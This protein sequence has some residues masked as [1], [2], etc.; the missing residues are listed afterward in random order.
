MRIVCYSHTDPTDG[1]IVP[2]HFYAEMVEDL[3]DELRR[4][5]VPKSDLPWDLDG[6]KVFGI[7]PVADASAPISSEATMTFEQR[8]GPAPK[9]ATKPKKGTK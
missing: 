9:P 7:D 8:P 6:S 1:R 2:V 4:A 5:T 3:C